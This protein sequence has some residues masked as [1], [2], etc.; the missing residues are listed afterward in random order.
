MSIEAINGILNVQRKGFDME[1]TKEKIKNLKEELAI[2]KEIAFE[3]QANARKI[4]RESKIL[5]EQISEIEKRIKRLEFVNA[6]IHRVI[7]LHTNLIKVHI[8]NEDE[9]TETG[10]LF[11]LIS[12]EGMDE[13]FK[14]LISVFRF[15]HVFLQPDLKTLYW[16]TS[17]GEFIKREL[18]NLI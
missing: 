3:Y 11:F 16:T 12:Y 18:V 15:S 6:R 10:T 8:Q 13:E 17:N 4:E 2:K 7:P 9:D 14:S 1:K 5:K